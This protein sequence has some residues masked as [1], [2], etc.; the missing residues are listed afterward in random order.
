MTRRLRRW[1]CARFGATGAASPMAD[2]IQRCGS[3]R[4][5][6]TSVDNADIVLR[7]TDLDKGEQRRSGP[8]VR[9]QDG[10]RIFRE[11][12]RR[13]FLVW[14]LV[15]LVIAVPEIWGSFGNPWFYSIS[16]TTGH[17]EDLWSGVRAIVVA[18][19]AVAAVHAVLYRPDM[20]EIPEHGAKSLLPG[21]SIR[22]TQ[23]GRLTIRHAATIKDGAREDV[24]ADDFTDKVAVPYL[25]TSAAVVAVAGWLAGVPQGGEYWRGYVIY[26]LIAVFFVIIPNAVAYF[27]GRDF[28]FTTLFAT[29]QS[30]ERT[31]NIVT[32]II[33]AG[34]AVLIFH[35][36]LYPWPDIHLTSG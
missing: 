25:L 32:M 6:W 15:A 8:P 33:M 18:L 17:L 12:T 29:V 16:R 5:W 19:I 30:L 34:L 26:G 23:L 4:Q 9:G 10:W 36:A 28:P 20:D 7:V 14:G 1:P 27:S 11:P 2:D 13:G 35:L 22:R 31:R 3:R 24:T 21:R